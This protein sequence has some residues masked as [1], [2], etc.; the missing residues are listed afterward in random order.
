MSL[1]EYFK[2]VDIQDYN[3]IKEYDGPLTEEAID[4]FEEIFYKYL[5][6]EFSNTTLNCTGVEEIVQIQNFFPE[7]YKKGVG[8][9]AWIRVKTD[10]GYNVYYAKQCNK[11]MS[12]EKIHRDIKRLDRKRN[13]NSKNDDIESVTVAPE[14]TKKKLELL[15]QIQVADVVN[16]MPSDIY[17]VK[18]LRTKSQ[19]TYLLPYE[20]EIVSDIQ[21]YVEAILDKDVKKSVKYR[22]LFTK[23]DQDQIFY[24]Q[25]RGI[26]KET[27]IMMCR[28]QQCYFVVDVQELFNEWMQPVKKVS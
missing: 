8:S 15:E 18:A 12:A 7:F 23:Q 3:T 20:Y 19:W 24:M 13:K 16:C 4:K 10:T 22:Q 9:G 17:Y 21:L 25:S 11:K 28:L 27:A 26:P 6:L 2:K 5:D 1:P 14:L